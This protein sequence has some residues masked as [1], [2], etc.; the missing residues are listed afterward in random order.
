MKIHVVYGNSY[1]GDFSL[2]HFSALTLDEC[3]EY[4]WERYG[5]EIV[6][7][8][9]PVTKEQFMQE[10][11][12]LMTD[13]EHFSS[14]REPYITYLVLDTDNLGEAGDSR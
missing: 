7:D 12:N 9:E 4:V 13:D 5:E 11:L 3:R 1:A 10:D 8:N 2:F 6:I 14:S